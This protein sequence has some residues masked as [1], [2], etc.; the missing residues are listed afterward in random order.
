MAETS[1]VHVHVDEHL[2]ADAAREIVVW[3][4]YVVIWSEDT[5]TVPI[6]RVLHAAQQWPPSQA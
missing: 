4:N 1:M 5:F 2:K 6:L 3:A